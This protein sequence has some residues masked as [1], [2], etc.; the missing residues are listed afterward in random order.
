MTDVFA[1]EALMAKFCAGDSR[2]F[3][4][5]Y[6]RYEKPLYR[7]IKRVLGAAMQAQTD[8]VF[9]ETWMKLINAKH[10]WQAREDA[11]FKTWLYTIAH[12][13]AVDKLRVSGRE[14]SADE[15]W[16]DSG[17]EAQAPSMMLLAPAPQ[18]SQPEQQAHWRKAGQQLLDCLEQLSPVQKTAFLLHH[19]EELS[20]EE[21]AGMVEAEFETVKSRLRYAMN[22]LRGCMGVHLHA[23]GETQ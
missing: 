6:E 19:E 21:I 5:L 1:D 7:Y 18:A 2:A 22:K 12:H 20:L 4:L 14:I 16:D 3:E 13:G 23:L 11:R 17:D 15:G 10:T 8:D 9:Q